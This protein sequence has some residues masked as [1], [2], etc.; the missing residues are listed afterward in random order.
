MNLLIHSQ[1]S[2]AAPLKWERTQFHLTLY[3][4]HNYLSMLGLKIIHISERTLWICLKQASHKYIF[5]SFLSYGVEAVKSFPIHDDVI[6]WKHFPR[7]WTFVRGIHRWPVK[8]PAQRAVTRSFDVCFDLRL[9]KRLSKQSWGL[10]LETL[11]RPLWR[12]C[13]DISGTSLSCIINTLVNTMA[14][15]GLATQGSGTTRKGIYLVFL[16]PP[17]QMTRI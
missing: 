4:E 14:A 16:Q 5:V 11:S 8:Y 3:N 12:H 15:D 7:Y 2:T 6:K 1:I 9:N 10:W 17:R 13:N